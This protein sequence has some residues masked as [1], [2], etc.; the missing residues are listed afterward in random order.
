M[1]ASPARPTAS[2]TGPW[3]VSVFVS[4]GFRLGSVGWRGVKGRAVFPIE[5]QL[6]QEDQPIFDP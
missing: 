3:A 6:D 5:N 2:S 1:S 4:C